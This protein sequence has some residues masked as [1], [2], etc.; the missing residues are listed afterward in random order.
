[1]KIVELIVSLAPDSGP[2]DEAESAEEDAPRCGDGS[3]T[4]FSSVEPD[5]EEAANIGHTLT[6][7]E[8]REIVCDGRAP[9]SGWRQDDF[10]SNGVVRHTVW[11]PP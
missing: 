6:A 5:V 7:A 4:D 9:P 10:G 3:N 8:K 11:T 2:S 1:M